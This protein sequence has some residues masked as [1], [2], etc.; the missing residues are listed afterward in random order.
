MKILN[1]RIDSPNLADAIEKVSRWIREPYTYTH[2]VTTPNP[3]IIMAAQKNEMYMHALNCAEL[4]L[5]DGRGLQ[6]AAKRYEERINYRITG[7]DF[8]ESLASMSPNKKWRWYLL[9][10]APGVA[11]QAANNLIKKYPGINIVKAEDGGS[12]TTDTLDSLDP[13]V[14]RIRS[15]KPDIVCVAFGAPKQELFM[16]MY[17]HALGAKVALGVGGTLDFISGKRKR[18]PKMIRILGLEW[19]Y[20][21]IREPRRFGRIY[22]AVVRFPL[23]VLRSHKG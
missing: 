6:W 17:K 5:P 1:V 19:L 13:L 18:A 10:G 16:E 7:V 4:A 22:T 11:K 20:R 3:E 2:I 21:L 23:A 15:S 12:V 9:G 14:S 8:I